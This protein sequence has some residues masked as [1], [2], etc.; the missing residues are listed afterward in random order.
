L[1]GAAALLLGGPALAATAATTVYS[2]GEILTMAGDQP[3][4]VEALVEQG[5]RILQVGPLAEALRLAGPGARRVDLAG[6]TLLPGFIDAHGHLPDYVTTWGRPDLSPPPVGTVKSV[7]DIQ[8]VVRRWLADHPAQAGQLVFFSGYDDSLLAEKRHPTRAD[9]D[10]VNATVPILLLHASGHLAVANS[11]ALALVK[12]DRSTP[13][14]AGGVIQR[15]PA[16]GEP[17]GVLE[18]TAGYPFLPLIPQPTLKQRLANLE[19][20]QRWWA[21]FGLTTAQ[22]GLSNPANL[23]LLR[24]AGRQGRLILDVVAYPFFKMLGDPAAL[25]PKLREVEIVKPGA[26]W[27]L[28]SMQANAG[29]EFAGPQAKPAGSPVP[30]GPPAKLRVGVYE[31]HLKIGGIKLTSDGSP[32][33]RTAYL[34]EP[35]TTP[36][37]GQPANY[38]AYPVMSQ[39][40]VDDWVALGWRNDIPILTHTNGDAAVEQLITAVARARARY[41]AKDLRPVAIHAQ[42]ARHDQVDRMAALGIVPSFFTA[43]TFFWGDWHRKNVGEARAA[44]ISPMAYAHRKGLRFTNHNDAPVVP[45]DMLRLTQTAVK[46]TTRSGFVLGPAERVS[47]YVALKAITDWAAYQYF[48]EASKG[49]LA[50]GK[51]ADLVILERNP[52]KVDPSAIQTIQVVETIKDGRSIYRLGRDRIDAAKAAAASRVAENPLQAHHHQHGAP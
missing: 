16:T 37:P 48:E 29:R 9:L 13:N 40:E 43:H 22:D 15:D 42:L 50:P 36:P 6:R 18:E 11:A 38:R 14:P 24:E 3:T 27:P 28:G 4:Y 31:N 51:R 47:P 32:Q 33:G 35:Y 30:G 46:R 5:G 49:T 17:N 12:I 20:V 52:L 34:S 1:A 2:G 19:E 23:E 39:Q 26:P 21:S 44:G 25:E 10:A 8:A 41:G 45:P 7:A